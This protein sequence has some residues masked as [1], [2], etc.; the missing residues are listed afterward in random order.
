MADKWDEITAKACLKR[1]GV[2]V[3]GKDITLKRAGIRVWG[4]I[5]YLVSKHKYNYM[6]EVRNA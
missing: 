5:D 1:N 4:A 2:D 6:K 3:K